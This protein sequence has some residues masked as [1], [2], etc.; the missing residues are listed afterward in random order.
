L[1]WVK[2]GANYTFTLAGPNRSYD[3]AF[4]G[5]ELQGAVSNAVARADGKR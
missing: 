1:E 4:E 2:K 3:A 5:L